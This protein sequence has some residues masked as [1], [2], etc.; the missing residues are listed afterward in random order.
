[1]YRFHIT[2]PV[3]F[4]RSLK[5]SVEHGRSNVLTLDLAS[6]AYWYQA[7]PHKTFPDLPSREARRPRPLINMRDIHQWRHEWRKSRGSDPTLWGTEPAQET[8]P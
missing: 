5:F 2:D 3:Y 4:D 1:M 6:V 7:E 8:K